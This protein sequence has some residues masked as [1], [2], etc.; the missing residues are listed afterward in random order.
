MKNLYSDPLF[1]IEKQYVRDFLPG[2]AKKKKIRN[3][4]PVPLSAA[5]GP[6]L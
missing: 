5:G 6:G 4:A 2:R 1:F 3:F